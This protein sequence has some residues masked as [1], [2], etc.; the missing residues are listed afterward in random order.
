VYISE[1]ALTYQNY[2]F[3]PRIWCAIEVIDNKLVTVD[4]Q[5][6]QHDIGLQSPILPLASE[7][8]RK[9][10]TSTE[11]D[12]K[13]RE[14]GEI[15]IEDEDDDNEF[16]IIPD[17]FDLSKK[18]EPQNKTADLSCDFNDSTVFGQKQEEI[19][20]HANSRSTLMLINELL[21]IPKYQ[22][23]LEEKQNLMTFSTSINETK[24][25]GEINESI[26]N[27][28]F[29]INNNANVSN[30]NDTLKDEQNLLTFSDDYSNLSNNNCNIKEEA[31]KVE[32]VCFLNNIGST[33]S[34][35]QPKPVSPQP[36]QQQQYPS[37][38]P[39]DRLLS[40]GFANRLLNKKLLDKHNDDINKV[41]E[42]LLTR[43]DHDWAS[44]RH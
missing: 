11:I 15:S 44:N 28:K 2:M 4:I 22:Q 41:I 19:V 43:A 32:N 40:M 13:F 20:D 24:H 17:C 16:V 29:E 6:T 33:A 30:L 9:F 35:S 8:N 10:S 42:D 26:E 25:D 36:P 31:E 1:W 3:G 27:M 21:L 34:S 38:E 14:I 18:W 37:L 7:I 39:I 23:Q 12:E 5:S